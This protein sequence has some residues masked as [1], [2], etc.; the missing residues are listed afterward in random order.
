MALTKVDIANR[1]L[2]RLDAETISSFDDGSDAA[3]VLAQLY[4][5][6]YLLV[7]TERAW[8]FAITDRELAQD[9]TAPTDPNWTYQ[10][11]L[12]SDYLNVVRY[13]GSGGGEITRYSRQGDRVLTNHST[14]F[15]KYTRKPDENELPPWFVNY[16]VLAVAHTIA[17]AVVAEGS[18][19]DRIAAELRSARITAFKQD[20]REEVPGNALAP[21]SYVAVRF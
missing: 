21:S 18:V 10:Y 13:Y 8:N 15:I 14:L 11:L 9:A 20:Q 4:D 7:L 19:Q 12:P 5:H 16:L 17:E 6:T 2:L 1:A 3:N